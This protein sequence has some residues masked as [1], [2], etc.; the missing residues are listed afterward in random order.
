WRFLGTDSGQAI[1]LCFHYVQA[2]PGNSLCK[3]GVQDSIGLALELEK[4][5]YGTEFPAKMKIGVSGCTICCSESYLRDIGIVGKKSGWTL[6]LGGNSGSNP[7]I[8]NVIVQKLTEEELFTI[9]DK[10]LTYYI[11]YA[12]KKERTSKFIKRIGIDEVRKNLGLPF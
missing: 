1:G 8:G 3:Y 5:Y 6:S 12:K 7:R 2:C 9:I 11:K 10:F 4:K